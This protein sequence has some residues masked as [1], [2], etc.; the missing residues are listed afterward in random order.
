MRELN[1]NEVSEISG[2]MMKVP[3]ACSPT[4]MVGSSVAG[5]IL[6][7]TGFAGGFAVGVATVGLGLIVGG[8]Y[9]LFQC[10][11][12]LRDANR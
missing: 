3:G 4:R 10:A 1:L 11:L 12:D 9:Q 7:T 5:G 6:G 2:G 8:G